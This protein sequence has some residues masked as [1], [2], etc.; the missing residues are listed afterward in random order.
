MK[1]KSTSQSAFFNL[2]VLIGLFVVLTGVFLALIGVG[3]FSG[4]TASSAKAQQTHKIINIAGLPP[5]FDCATIHDLGIDRMEGLRAGLILIACGESPGGSPTSFGAFSQL[6]NSL[7]APLAFG[8]TD[9]NLITGTET[10][11]HVIQSETY[12][13]ANPDNADQICVAY[14]DSRGAA[15]NNFSGISCSTDGGV[16]FTRVTTAGG[17]SPF[18]N[19]FGDP[20]VLY[21]KPTGTW[22]TIW[23]DGNGS[24]T[25]GGYKS[26]NPL[27]ATSWTHFC[28][29]NNGGDDR[30]SGWA[31]NNP[32]SPHF[33]NMYVSWNDFNLGNAN[34]VVSRSTDNGATWS[35]EI[36]VSTQS[37]F[38]R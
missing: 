26:T 36:T 35:S 34:V 1:Q 5:G 7:E 13:T 23:L 15:S 14:N 10:S 20:V 8:G 38:I 37:T 22:F 21:N 6:L 27:D 31:D 2:R 25:L 18:A 28:V 17:Q 3:T 4:L 11:P 32:S 33:G 24:C 19:T 30:E 29:H 9:V 16:T 12:S